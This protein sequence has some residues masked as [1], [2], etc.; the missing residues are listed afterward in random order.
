MSLH[1]DIIQYQ[2]HSLWFD[3]ISGQIYDSQHS[4]RAPH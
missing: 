2:F 3:Q 1:S 4:R